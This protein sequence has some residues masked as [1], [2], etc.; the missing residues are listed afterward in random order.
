MNQVLKL[1]QKLEVMDERG[2]LHKAH[3]TACSISSDALRVVH[4]HRTFKKIILPLSNVHCIWTTTRLSIKLEDAF[5]DT[6]RKRMRCSVCLFQR[7][8]ERVNDLIHVLLTANAVSSALGVLEAEK[9]L[10]ILFAVG[11]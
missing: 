6:E 1:I 5:D 3:E 10:L 11:D 8:D 7:E 9:S 2:S 4:L